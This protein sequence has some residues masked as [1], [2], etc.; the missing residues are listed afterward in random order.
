MNDRCP[1]GFPRNACWRC[2][3]PD[4]PTWTLW[5]PEEAEEARTLGQ[6]TVLE[7]L[8]PDET[9]LQAAERL[10]VVLLEP[11]KT[12][13]QALIGVT[14]APVDHWPRAGGVA[15]AVYDSLKCVQAIMAAEDWNF[16]EAVE[17]FDF[18]TAAS[19][20]GEGTPTFVELVVKN[21]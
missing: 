18:N 16:E 9:P 4:L 15:C 20:V 11:R 17:W 10:G 6:P 21:V 2:S 1:C 3:N 5:A 7:K 14:K 8:L 12:F 13:D 19:W